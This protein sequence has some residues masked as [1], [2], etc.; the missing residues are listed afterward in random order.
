MWEPGQSKGASKGDGGDNGRL[1][2]YWRIDPISNYFE[3]NGTLESHCWGRELQ[4][5]KVEN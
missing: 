4:T 3:D 1:I 5:W 2:T